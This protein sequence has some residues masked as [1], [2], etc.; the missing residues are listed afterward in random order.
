ME[1]ISRRR[2][3]KVGVAAAGVAVLGGA[4]YAATLAPGYDQPSKTMGDGMSKALV[5]YGTATGCTEAIA[6]RIAKVLSDRGIT[7]EIVPGAKAPDPAPYDAVFVGSGVRMG[8]WH[9]P[10]KDWVSK[11]AAALKSKK[12]AFYTVGLTLAGDPT[13]TAEVRAFT[14]PLIAETGVTPVDIGTF[15]GA[16]DPAK[17]S[18]LERTILGLMKS[19]QGDFRD[20]AAIEAWAA[21]SADAMGLVG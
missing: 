1:E 3:L 7:A 5:V 12:V 15:A 13:K 17:F 14:D 19:P 11:N 21:K 16:N 20:W 10:V 8:S 2:F 18:F 6:E 4:G 9:T